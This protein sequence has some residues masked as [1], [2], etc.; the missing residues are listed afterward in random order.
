MTAGGKEMAVSAQ[1]EIPIAV[2]SER[3]LLGGYVNVT[4]RVPIPVQ[5]AN[6]PRSQNLD[7]EERND[8]CPKTVVRH[9]ICSE[10]GSELP[11][12]REDSPLTIAPKL[13]PF[14]GYH[15]CD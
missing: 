8:C 11:E 13:C 10:C 12:I 1:I 7:I 2:P 14:C 15:Q 9:G 6:E 5:V 3:P 4:V